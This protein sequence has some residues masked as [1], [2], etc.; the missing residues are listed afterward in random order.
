M[1][2]D[3]LIVNIDFVISVHWTLTIVGL[4]IYLVRLLKR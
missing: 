1:F 3:T 4:S 2:V